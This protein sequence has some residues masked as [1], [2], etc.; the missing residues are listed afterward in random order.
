MLLS[1]QVGRGQAGLNW[2]NRL[3]VHKLIVVNLI[4][5]DIAL[6]LVEPV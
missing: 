5:N 6:H 3:Q 4:L 1:V 2:L